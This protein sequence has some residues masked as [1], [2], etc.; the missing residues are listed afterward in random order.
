MKKLLATLCV[1]ALF[2]A[3]NSYSLTYDSSILNTK[4]FR[5]TTCDIKVNG[6]I[7]IDQDKVTI[8]ERNADIIILTDK[9]S[10]SVNGQT[11]ALTS[12]EQ[13][14][15]KD[16][17]D[18]IKS[19]V[20][21]AIELAA[22]AIAITNTALTEVFTGL[23]GEDSQLPKM[24]NKKLSDLQ[25]LLEEQVYQ[26]PNSYT[27]NQAFFGSDGELKGELEQSLNSAVEEITATAMGEFMML[28]GK[29]MMS[30]EGSA[31]DF[32]TRM[33]NLGDNI[34]SQITEQSKALEDDA[35]RL[36]DTLQKVDDT[37]SNLQKINGLN[38]LDF[39]KLTQ[40]SA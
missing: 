1:T 24:I 15:V 6:D 40:K 21:Q 37:E 29:S 3:P 8:T 2:Y 7:V 20:P 11:L 39:L 13:S 4:N 33:E 28:L 17:V 36:C 23:L 5:N 16:Y 19:A 35:N 30:G 27:F 12:E 22:K 32:Q 9:G 25:N 14:Y 26:K 18:G 38:R 34:E 31:K 10:A